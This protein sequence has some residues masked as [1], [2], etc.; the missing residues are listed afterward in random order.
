V[1]IEDDGSKQ[2]LACAVEN[3]HA[4]AYLTMFSAADIKLSTV[5]IG[6]LSVLQFVESKPDLTS[7]P[8]VLNIVDDLVLLSMIFQNGVNVF[9]SRTR[10]Y[11]EDRAALVRSTLDGLS[12]IIQFNKSQNFSDVLICYYLGLNDADMELISLN[13]SYPGITFKP[14]FI[15]QEAKGSGALQPGAHFA[16]LNTLI[17]DSQ[18]DLLYDIRMLEKAKHRKRPKKTWIPILTGL[19]LLLAT[20]ITVLFIMVS[21]IERDIQKLNVFLNDP[22]LVTE[23]NQIEELADDTARINNLYDAIATQRD[24]TE[25]KPQVSNQLL[26]AI[27]RTGGNYVT[28]NGMSFSSDSRTISVSAS[29]A[30]E[31]DA[32]AYVEALTKSAMIDTVVYGGYSPGSAGEY[33]FSIDIVATGWREGVSSDEAEPE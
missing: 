28:I 6:I 30:T 31:R 10:L 32:A 33:I 20:V 27:I 19:V 2:I 14:L 3:A 25:V 8:F 7:K 12:G 23:K 22:A 26:D 1:C 18:T 11:G 5:H 13:T 21:G 4:L 17:P 9:Q 16:Y 29:S 24:K 15:Y